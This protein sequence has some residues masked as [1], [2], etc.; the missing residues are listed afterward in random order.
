MR[1]QARFEG[2]NAVRMKEQSLE[3]GLYI[4]SRTRPI[5]H[6]KRLGILPVLNVVMATLH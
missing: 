5:R 6:G 4:Y 1:S 2:W 3:E